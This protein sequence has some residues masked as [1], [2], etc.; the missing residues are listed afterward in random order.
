MINDLKAVVA[1]SQA[2]LFEDMLGAVAL[3][4][5][6]VGGLSLPALI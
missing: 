6:L 1:R 5:I 2:T 3:L 4:V